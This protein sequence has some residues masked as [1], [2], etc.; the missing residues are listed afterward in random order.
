MIAGI[1]IYVDGVESSAYTDS[2]AGTYVAMENTTTPVIVGGS[3]L[4]YGTP[5]YFLGSIKDVRIYNR[6]LTSDEI[7]QLYSLG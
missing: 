5:L 3:L 1:K 6:A 4:S 7:S 2:S